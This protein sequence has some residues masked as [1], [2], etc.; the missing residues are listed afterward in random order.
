MMMATPYILSG[1]GGLLLRT[2]HI[3][4][5]LNTTHP[6]IR[7]LVPKVLLKLM[8]EHTAVEEPPTIVADAHQL[9]WCYDDHLT[10]EDNKEDSGN[11]RCCLLSVCSKILVR[12]CI[13]HRSMALDGAFLYLTSS[14]GRRLLKVGSGVDGSIR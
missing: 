9:C 4:Q 12:A 11:G 3:L 1:T 2:V 10:L 13:G 7:L 8:Q 5:L 14:T 6:D